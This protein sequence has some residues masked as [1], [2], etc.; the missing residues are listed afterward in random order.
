M[1]IVLLG[2]GNELKKDDGIGNIIARE[3]KEAERADFLSIPAET[4]P[5]NFTSVI[6]KVEPDILV[7]VDAAQMGLLPGEFRVLSKKRLGSEGFGTHGMPLSH[8]V[9]YLEDY[10]RKIYFIGIQPNSVDMGDEISPE[11]ERGKNDLIEI[12]KKKEWKAIEKME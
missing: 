7:I 4:V 1:K 8:L 12:I 2:I 5:E 9:T 3:F 11:V 6:R 10:A